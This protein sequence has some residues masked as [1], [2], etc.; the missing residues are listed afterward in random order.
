MLRVLVLI[1]LFSVSAFA[2]DEEEWTHFTCP[3]A[4]SVGAYGSVKFEYELP[5]G[6]APVLP[7]K[8]A[9]KWMATRL[10]S[11]Q[12]SLLEGTLHLTC[13]YATGGEM[14]ADVERL[15]PQAELKFTEC[16]KEHAKHCAMKGKGAGNIERPSTPA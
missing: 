14:I 10:V 16:I 11:Q 9:E 5:P 8:Q 3:S 1:L 7:P 15:V 4:N 13:S 2:D 6:W 12:L